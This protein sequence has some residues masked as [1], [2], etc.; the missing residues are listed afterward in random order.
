MADVHTSLFDV[1]ATSKHLPPR[2]DSEIKLEVFTPREEPRPIR[3]L[4]Y[5]NRNRDSQFASEDVRYM[6]HDLE[7]PSMRFPRSN[8]NIDGPIVKQESRE[9]AAPAFGTKPRNSGPASRSNSL[10]LGRGNPI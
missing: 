7:E 5:H 9:R 3:N 4:R 6:V 10:G 2:T 1:K 8:P